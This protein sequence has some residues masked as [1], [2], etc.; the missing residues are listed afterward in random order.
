MGT[1]RIARSGPAARAAVTVWA[2]AA[3]I[4]AL[5]IVIADRPAVSALPLAVAAGA[6][7]V[8]AVIG[9]RIVLRTVG[10]IAG[11]I[12][13][14]IIAGGP[15]YLFYSEVL[16]VALVL[17]VLFTLYLLAVLVPRRRHVDTYVGELI[18]VLLLGWWLLL[19]VLFF[20]F[21]STES[22]ERYW[23]GA[24]FAA[25]M[26]A[27]V[28]CG[29]AVPGRRIGYAVAGFGLAVAAGLCFA[30]VGESWNGT[31]ALIGLGSVLGGVAAQITANVLS[32][33][34]PPAETA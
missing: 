14:A 31:I 29:A 9:P 17:A 23:A 5:M 26:A 27:C 8:I 1:S 19:Y 30:V 6:A 10:W 22:E 15:E 12:A 3:V 25:A 2:V 16:D 34:R 20:G 13:V 32:S 18:P 11:W 24:G 33:R 28:I 7:F 21:D 4:S